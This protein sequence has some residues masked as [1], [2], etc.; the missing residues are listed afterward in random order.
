M[1]IQ[2]C[3]LRLTIETALETQHELLL[4]G[5]KYDTENQAPRQCYGIVVRNGIIQTIASAGTWRAMPAQEVYKTE[6]IHLDP[7]KPPKPQRERISKAERREIARQ[8]QLSYWEKIENTTQQLQGVVVEALR[9]IG[10]HEKNLFGTNTK[11]MARKA[12][13]EA[14]I[15]ECTIIHGAHMSE[16]MLR[17]AIRRVFTAQGDGAYMIPDAET[18]RKIIKS[19]VF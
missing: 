9:K 2:S 3:K 10:Q 13:W 6:E 8:A 1:M 7:P 19:V 4:R 11:S 5:F 16:N 14:F 15:L 12:A 18:N 17:N